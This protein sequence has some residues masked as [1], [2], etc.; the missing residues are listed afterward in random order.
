[1]DY[2]NQI[3]NNFHPAINKN[4]GSKEVE[5]DYIPVKVS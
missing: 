3:L 2:V 1:M 5:I 4:V